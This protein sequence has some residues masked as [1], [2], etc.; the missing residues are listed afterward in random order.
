MTVN[1]APAVRGE[2]TVNV[3]AGRITGTALW[4]RT[5]ALPSG[6]EY[7]LLADGAAV[8]SARYCYHADTHDH[9]IEPPEPTHA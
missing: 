1:P 9:D 4:C 5:C 3:S 7:E 8:G 6:V 2:V